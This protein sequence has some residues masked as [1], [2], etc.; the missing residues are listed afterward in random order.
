M[1]A[2]SALATM[3]AGCIAGAR[4]FI[5]YARAVA[6]AA[7]DATFDLAARQI[8]GEIPPDVEITTAGPV[9]VSVLS[10]VAFL[11]FT[12]LGLVSLYLA[13]SGAVRLIS[14]C[15]DEPFGDPILTG[16]DRLLTRTGGRV[17]ASHRRR[18]RARAE[19]PEAPDRL[20]TGEWA[21]LPE[22]TYVVV[23][24]RRK[25]GWRKGVFVITDDQW[26]TLGEPF[27][28]QLPEGLR[29]VYPLREQTTNEV[30][31]EGVRY[32]LPRLEKARRRGAGSRM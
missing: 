11:C 5:D 17:A 13:A 20:F 28:L 26:Y 9:A 30:L 23:S 24:S 16:L 15:V 1:G 19:G 27:D 14:A 22:V 4:G 29:T 31:R 3:M 8:R 10:L 32:D 12:P 2:L 18:A 21:G 7:N 6:S 25:D